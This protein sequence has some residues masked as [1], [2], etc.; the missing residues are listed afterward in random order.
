MMREILFRA[1]RKD[2]KGW[3][4]GF[5]INKNLIRKYYKNSGHLDFEI[6]PE[7]IGQFTGLFDKNGDKI[8]EGDKIKIWSFYH[9]SGNTADWFG[10]EPQ[11]SQPCYEEFLETMYATVEFKNGNFIAKNINHEIPLF[12]VLK[13]LGSEVSD[14]Y[15][16]GYGGDE[17]SFIECLNDESYGEDYYNE[18]TMLEG[19]QFYNRLEEIVN[20]I[21][22]EI[23][24]VNAI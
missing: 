2:G 18:L 24:I 17:K 6:Y 9:K 4:E 22:K 12:E 10:A 1:K 23:E 7:T 3:V 11:N 19:E 16:C 21:T 20:E 13:G 14:F 8:F 5:L 15:M